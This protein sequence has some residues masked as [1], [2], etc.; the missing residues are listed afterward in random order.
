VEV[1]RGNCNAEALS[2]APRH[3][4]PVTHEAVAIHAGGVVYHILS[5]MVY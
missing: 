1:R 4:L 5:S 3:V 2:G